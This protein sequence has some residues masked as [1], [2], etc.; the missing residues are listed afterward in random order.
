MLTHL[1]IILDGNR[2]WARNN[3]LQVFAGHHKGGEVLDNIINFCLKEKIKILTIY[4]LSSKNL[5]NRSKEELA[6]HFSLHK[7][8]IERELKSKRYEKDG[9][10]FNVIGRL[11]NLPTDEQ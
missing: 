3:K 9:I 6:V 4:A 1:A 8:Y 2:R 5:E 11:H 10:R 7:K